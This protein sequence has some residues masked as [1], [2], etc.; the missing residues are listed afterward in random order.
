[1]SAADPGLFAL[2]SAIR[3][4]IVMPLAFAL[5][6]EVIGEKQ[7]A[8]FAAFGSMALLVFVDFGGSRPA[9]L[10]AY[11]LLALAGAILIVF[12]TLCSRSAWLA[13]SA[14]ALVAF[15]IL[16]CGVLNSYVAA[17][18]AAAM[19]TFVLPVMVSAQASAIPTRLAGWGLAAA[20]SIPAL[21]L[22]WPE[23][24]RGALRAQAARAMRALAVL[25]QL[26]TEDDE[27]AEEAA[28]TAFQQTRAL[29]SRFVS[30][31][32]RPS[33]T[34]RRTAALGRLVEDLGWLRP[35]A[36]RAPR[37]EI[38]GGAFSSQR[39]EIEA[40]V[41]M[42]LASVADRLA[43]GE[44]RSGEEQC[45]AV[46]R[47]ERVRRAHD[48]LGQALV[49]RFGQAAPELDE[50]EA[51]L[52]LDEAYR[53]RQLSFGT[54][55]TGRDALLACGEAVAGDPLQTRRSRIDA[56]GRLARSHATMRSVWLRNSVRGAAGLAIAVLVGQLTDLQHAFWIVLGTMSVLRSNAL[57]TGTTIVWALL[58]TLA[59]IVVGGLLVAGVGS[60][61]AAL[62]AVLVPAVALAAY[63]PRAISFA[64][65]QAA[66]SMVVLILFN[67]IDPAGWRVGI[68]R[69]EDVAIGAGVSLL[70]GVL[71]WP[72]GA[73]AVLREAIGAAYTRA[74]EYLDATID[75]LLGGVGSEST[76]RA[77]REANAAAQLLD[78]TV[79]D[80]LAERSSSRMSLD[81]LAV[82]VAGASRA[83]RVAR[84]LQNAH[85]FARLAPVDGRLPRL[86]QARTEFD[87]KRH[88]RCS[89]YASLG[90][91]VAQSRDPPPPESVPEVESRA[92]VAQVVLE[93][94]PDTHG[95]PP[96]VALAWA[97]RHLGTLAQLEPALAHAGGRIAQ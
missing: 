79:R 51:T 9:R 48:A 76:E 43:L 52:E 81:D 64:A 23:R 39:A 5:S 28:T 80:Y 60:D 86:S 41:P 68:V 77:A 18:H 75:A 26:R 15:T 32:H 10:R 30:L 56:A 49:E 21:L 67:L 47:L 40:A 36:A 72:R 1:M 45:A 8:L 33:G 31:P 50:M 29:R 37:I 44:E 84:L 93:S 78:A 94:A 19:L 14:M 4:A 11:L 24:P 59:G 7:M 20:L 71:I 90:A 61:R 63:A 87:S 82:L 88:A 22:L 12:G 57:A 13:T 3:T 53:L 58:G 27:S 66:F 25:V 85:T 17:A 55:Q 97:D 95:V 91:A 89:W 6:L 2:K 54:L 96:G 42:A 70:S 69:V 74:A 73:T 16:F 35:L 83:R 46:S 62:W 38:G 65:G 34:A 92:S